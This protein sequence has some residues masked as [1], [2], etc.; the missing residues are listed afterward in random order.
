MARRHRMACLYALAVIPHS[1]A[2]GQLFLVSTRLAYEP[3][4]QYNLKRSLIASA[5]SQF[6]Y[7]VSSYPV[8]LS[9]F[10]LFIARRVVS[11][12]TSLGL[13][14]LIE[15]FATYSPVRLFPL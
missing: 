4:L 5:P 7:L 2:T 10:S 11:S 3:Y 6:E 9:L 8:H 15:H 14:P 1:S 13:F 12:R